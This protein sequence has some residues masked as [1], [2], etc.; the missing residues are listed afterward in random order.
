M[1]L[2]PEPVADATQGSSGWFV[3]ESA[4]TSEVRFLDRFDCLEFVRRKAA[5]GI[6]GLLAGSHFK[7]QVRARSTAGT[8]NQ[9]N[10]IS[11]V[12]LLPFPDQDSTCMSISSAQVLSVVDD[13]HPSVAAIHSSGSCEDYFAV[14]TGEYGRSSLGQDVQA[15]VQSAS[16]V[17]E[18]T[19]YGA[20]RQRE[21]Q[22][23]NIGKLAQLR[24]S[25]HAA[26]DP[27]HCAK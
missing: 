9:S 3:S 1:R 25:G 15:R 20:G 5:Q 22:V 14:R 26:S 23:G 18:W 6:E 17:P 19:R 11:T 10:L 24:E 12:Y 7:V 21:F 16:A 4:A 27:R 8:A 13:H 2:R